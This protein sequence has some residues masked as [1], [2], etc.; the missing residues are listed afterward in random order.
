MIYPIRFLHESIQCSPDKVVAY[1]SKLENLPKWAAGVGELG[2]VEVKFAAANPFGVVDH[3]VRVGS[4][5]FHNPM[6]VIPNG[7]GSEIV[8]ALYRLPSM[9][10]ADFERDAE[11]IL[12]DFRKLKEILESGAF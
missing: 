4:D 8:F 1:V 12:R 11:S 6:R 7:D 10:D 9:S 2:D 5:T 3:D